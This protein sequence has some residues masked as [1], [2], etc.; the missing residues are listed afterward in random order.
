AGYERSK[1]KLDAVFARV[2]ARLEQARAEGR[3][4]LV[5]DS[6]TVADLTFAALAMPLL[7]PRN[8]GWPLPPRDLLPPEA[9]ALSSQLASTVAGAHALRVYEAHRNAA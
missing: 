5:G 3:N 1:V 6:F 2:G 9:S 4:Y 7:G 8:A